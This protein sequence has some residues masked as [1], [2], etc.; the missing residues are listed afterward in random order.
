MSRARQDRVVALLTRRGEWTTAAELA[1][2][3]GV[4][5]RSIRSYVTALNA[6]VPDGV[7]VESGPQGYRLGPDAGAALRTTGPDASA[8]RER[9]HRHFLRGTG[10]NG[11]LVRVKP[12]LA[13]LIEFRPHNLMNARWSLGEPFDLVFCR[14]VLIYFDDASRR[15]AAD[16]IFD[17][18][19]PGGFVCLGH[20]ESMSRISPLFRVCRYDDAIVYR[21]P[22]EGEH[23]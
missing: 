12:E 17:A 18:L 20:T 1:D 4:T 3:I 10:G 5:P 19:V 15:L 23:V 21:R 14:N 22:R 7:V 13:R 16:N 8:P 9:L 11:G 2:A 6:R